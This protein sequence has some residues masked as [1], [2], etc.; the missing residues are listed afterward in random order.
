MNKVKYT[1]IRVLII[2]ISLLFIDEDKTILLICDNIQIHLN[3]DQNK[4]IE[5][6]HQHNF[7]R[8]DDDVKWINLTSFEL[9]ASGEKL[10][11]FPCFHIKRTEDYKGLVWQP[12]K[13]V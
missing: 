7:S 10:L 6:P 12:P 5:I 2:F 13:S 1:I 3:D 8:N 4:D 9:S 11:Y